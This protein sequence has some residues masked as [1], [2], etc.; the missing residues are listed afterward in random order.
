MSIPY[1]DQWVLGRSRWRRG[2]HAAGT[3]PLGQPPCE[4]REPPDQASAEQEAAA[5]VLAG[6]VPKAT[7]AMRMRPRWIDRDT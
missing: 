5:Q 4:G 7:G 1:K 6:A 3:N 2:G